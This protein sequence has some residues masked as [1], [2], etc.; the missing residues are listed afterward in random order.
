MLAWIRQ[1]HHFAMRQGL[2]PVVLSTLLAGGLFAGRVYLS[3][4][5]IFIG[6]VWNLFLAWIPYLVSLGISLTNPGRPWRWG[7]LFSLG[8]VW[9]AFFPNA[10]YIV[11]DFLHLE[12]RPPIPIWY[13]IAF[14]STFA[15]SGLFLGV[16]S[17]RT[18]QSLVRELAGQLAGWLFVLGVIGLSGLGIYLGR[19]LGWNSWDLLFHPRAIVA[20]VTVRLANPLQHPGTFGVTLIFAL[21]LLVCY[22]T[23]TANPHP[24]APSPIVGR[25]GGPSVG[26]GGGPPVGRGEGLPVG[27]GRGSK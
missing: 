24:P 25:G 19:F 23:V 20:D 3:S 14:L 11:T 21:F 8:L 22:L 16:F 17:L 26:R 12:S 18:M 7:Y 5:L 6:L 15:W 4:S 1:F 2:Y 13:D 9:L 27:R 10:P